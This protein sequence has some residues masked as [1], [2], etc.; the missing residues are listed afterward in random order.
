MSTAICWTPDVVTVSHGPLWPFLIAGFSLIVGRADIF[1]RLFLCGVD[2]GTCVLIYLLARD[3]FGKRIGLIA[4]LFAC[5]YPALYIYTGWLYTE[6]LSTFLQTAVCY[7]VFRI[8]R[9]GRDRVFGYASCVESLLGLL[10]LYSP[11]WSSLMIGLVLV[12]AAILY[13]RRLLPRPSALGLCWPLWLPV[14]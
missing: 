10:S 8:Q 3:L 9:G 5:I 1:D 14:R 4:G 12:W 6:A 13:W 2:A 11:Q 7:C